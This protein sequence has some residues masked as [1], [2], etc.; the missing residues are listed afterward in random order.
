MLGSIQLAKQVFQRHDF[1]RQNQI[2]IVGVGDGVPDYVRRDLIENNGSYYAT[3][4]VVPGKSI[5]NIDVPVA[6]FPFKIPGQTT[7]EPNPWTVNFRTPGDY[8]LRNSLER[9]SFH[10]M[11]EESM[12]GAFQ[13]PCDNATLDI[14]VFSPGCQAIKGYKLIGVWPQ[15]IGSIS[16]DQTAVEV[17]Q[18]DVALHY[19]WWRPIDIN[20]SE[21]QQGATVFSSIG[22][23]TNEIENRYQDLEATANVV[24]TCGLAI[25]GRN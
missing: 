13:M 11:N 12:C 2:R 4:L 5:T 10:V 20:D 9:W 3:T 7:Y 6:G 1:S 18:F 14:A 25:P 24:G 15:S 23:F 19:Q 17:T 8:F 21:F 16:Y 22:S